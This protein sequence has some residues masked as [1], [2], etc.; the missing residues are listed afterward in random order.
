MPR[1]PSIA[2]ELRFFL[3]HE[4]VAIEILLKATRANAIPKG[5]PIYTSLESVLCYVSELIRVRQ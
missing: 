3:K 4:S 5:V 1:L 2:C